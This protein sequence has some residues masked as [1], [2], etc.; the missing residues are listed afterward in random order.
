MP[1]ALATAF[2][3]RRTAALKPR[4]RPSPPTPPPPSPLRPL[5]TPCPVPPLLLLRIPQY[6]KSS[7]SYFRIV[8]PQTCTCLHFLLNTGT[9]PIRRVGLARAPSPPPPPRRPP[10]RPPPPV[11]PPPSPPPPSPPPPSPPPRRPPPPSPPPPRRPP[12]VAPP[13]VAPPPPVVPPPVVPPPRRP[14]PVV[15]LR[16]PAPPPGARSVGTV[17]WAPVQGPGGSRRNGGGVLPPVQR[18]HHR[19]GADAARGQTFWCT[20]VVWCPP[21]APF[22]N[23]APS[24]VGGC[25]PPQTPPLRPPPPQTPPPLPLKTLGQIF[26]GAFGVN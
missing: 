18:I 24:G 1:T 2:S 26:S 12:P 5:R 6:L 13:P 17:Q 15:P 4:L 25:P 7:E 23:S 19:H 16:P 22:H 11:L 9:H 21:G 20:A 8:H 14:P 10:P 3:P